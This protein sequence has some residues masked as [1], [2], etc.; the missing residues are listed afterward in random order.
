MKPELTNAIPKIFYNN[1]NS[2]VANNIQFLILSQ[3]EFLSPT[4]R[5][6]PSQSKNQAR[7]RCEPERNADKWL[8]V[9]QCA[10]CVLADK[11]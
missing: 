2:R 4:K 9:L 8:R 3:K 6:T 1:N 7:T 11:L 10:H 5:P